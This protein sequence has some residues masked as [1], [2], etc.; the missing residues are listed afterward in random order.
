MAIYKLNSDSIESLPAPKFSDLGI[1]ER[2]DLQRLLRDNVKVIAP[3][4]LVISEEF[5]QWD[6][7]KRRIDLLA[8]DKQANVV[9]IELKRTEDGGHMELQALRYAAMVSTLSFNQAVDVFESYLKKRGDGRN[10]RE[11]L[12]GFL[13]WDEPDEESFAS[14]VRIIL[15]SAEFSKELTTTVI[16]L[17][18]RDVD[19]RCVRLKP[20]GVQNDVLLDVQQVI[21]LPEAQDYQIQVREKKQAERRSKQ[22]SRD[23]TK[24][25]VTVGEETTEK[26]T[27][28]R[29][30]HC[31][32]R[33][34]LVNGISPG[35]V[36][37]I[38][39][40]FGVSKRRVL[41]AADGTLSEDEIH[42]H[43]VEV[44]G[45]VDQTRRYFTGDD[46]LIHVGGKTIAIS[47][48]WG[49]NTEPFLDSVF[50]KFQPENISYERWNA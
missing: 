50:K 37:K 39:E 24:Y 15:A 6:Q 4:V 14:D 43:I 32:L 26:L 28:N 19:I 48:Q 25:N 46:E 3:D 44:T 31:V 40:E 21:P 2:G 17:L 10:A 22:S 42:E 41:V 38:P 34:L 35:D 27:K 8:I 49:P 5:G 47:S 23:F 11:T 12:L 9:V 33:A 20:Y 29:T 13:E 45:S 18:D 36:Q 1:S 7:S 30:V 16:W